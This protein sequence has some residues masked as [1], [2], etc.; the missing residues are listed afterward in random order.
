[1][2]DDYEDRDYDFDD[3]RDEYEEREEGRLAEI[4]DNCTCGAWQFNESRT[5]VFHVADCCCGAE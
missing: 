4:A 1:M 2:E 3:D 5:K